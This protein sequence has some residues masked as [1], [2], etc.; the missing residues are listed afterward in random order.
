MTPSPGAR[1]PRRI[2]L[3]AVVAVCAVAV[4]A[5][6]CSTRPSDT[7]FTGPTVF[8]PVLSP[9]AASSSTGPDYQ[10][11]V[12]TAS[13]KLYQQAHDVYMQFFTYDA[14]LQQDG[15]ADQLPPQLTAVLAGDALKTETAIHK[16]AK[17]NGFHWV[18]GVPKIW[19]VKV[20]QLFDEVPRGTVIAL[21]ACEESS[22]AQLFR[23]DG[24]QLSDGRP[25][26]VVYHY[27]LKYDDQHQLVIDNITGGGEAVDAC[28]F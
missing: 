10:T 20:A 13:P 21:Q 2:L 15:G 5:S 16:A 22:G 12:P 27:F 23:G 18:G 4:V 9:S 24:T 1:L 6:G 19:T 26:I 25:T 7:G 3:A 14:A 11:A 8:L 28:P 17:A